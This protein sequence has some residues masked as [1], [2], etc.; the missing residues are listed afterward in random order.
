[1]QRFGSPIPLSPAEAAR[2]KKRRYQSRSDEEI[3]SEMDNRGLNYRHGWPQL[4]P[5]PVQT[6]IQGAS[7]AVHNAPQHITRV[8][9]ILAVQRIQT[10]DVYFAYR[11]PNDAKHD[12]PVE[13]FLTLVVTVNTSMSVTFVAPIIQLRQYL[14]SQEETTDLFI[15]LIDYRAI[16]GLFTIPISHKDTAVLDSWDHVGSL[17]TSEISGFHEKWLSIEVLHRGLI[18][19]RCSPTIVIASPTAGDEIWIKA[20][21]PAIRQKLRNL[22]PLFNVEVLCAKTL[23]GIC[24]SD[25]LCVGSYAKAIAMG[26]SIGIPNDKEH[27]GTVGGFVTLS[28]GKTYGLTNHHVVRDD[29]VDKGKSHWKVI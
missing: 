19:H 20:I 10:Y 21:V 28:N 5:L 18:E 25:T 4:P 11:V 15:E 6:F 24:K 27:A 8:Q 13:A 26:S 23:T 22:N 12:E 7:L 17:V 29:V 9:N 3:E 1:M 2:R 14:K 16:D